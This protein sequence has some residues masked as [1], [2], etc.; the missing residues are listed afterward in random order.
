MFDADVIIAGAGPGGCALAARL[1][2]RDPALA[3][4]TILL[5]RATFPRAKPC[6]GGPT[7]HAAEAMAAA[8]LTLTVPAAEAPRARI[9]FAGYQRTVALPRPVLVV[10]RE[11][12]DASL[13]AQ[14]RAHGAC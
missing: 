10:R 6:G 9:R 8:G 5:D 7:G 1:A 4:R 2:G 12:F 3:R 14:A 13:V 11:E